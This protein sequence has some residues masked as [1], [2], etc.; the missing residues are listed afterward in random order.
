MTCK[1]YSTLLFVVILAL[2]LTLALVA[3]TEEEDKEIFGVTFEDL[4]VDYDGNPHSITVTGK[5]PAGVSVVYGSNTATEPGVYSAIAT[6]YGNG[7]VTVTLTAKLTIVAPDVDITGVTFEDL[8]VFYDGNPHEITVTG[9]LPNGVTVTYENN[10]ATEVGEYLATAVLSGKGYNDLALSATLKIMLADADTTG[11][12]FEDMTVDF[13][14]DPHELTVSGVLPEGVSVSY[15]NNVAT[16]AGEYTVSATFSQTN[17]K[18]VILTAKL[19]INEVPHA[20]VNNSEELL[21]ALNDGGLILFGADIVLD[22]GDVAAITKDTR[23]NGRGHTLSAVNYANNNYRVIDIFGADVKNVSISNLNITADKQV[24]YLRG[25]NLYETKNLTLDV[26]NVTV[27]LCDYYGFNI[28]RLN[29]N[30]NVNMRDCEIS[31]WVA[32]YNH[33]SGVTFNA[34]RCLFKG[35][36]R[37]VSSGSTYNYCT[38]FIVSEYVMVNPDDEFSI[39]TISANNVFRLTDCEIIARIL[40]NEETGETIDTYQNVID[41]R[42][43]YNNRLELF[44]ITLAPVYYE[45]LIKCAY[46]SVYIP[47]ENRDDPDYVVD[48]NKVYIDG[49]DVTENDSLVDKYFDEG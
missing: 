24:S 20:I 38:T 23:L 14:G 26:S 28:A 41:L 11:V 10:T 27:N 44:N 29:D 4:T 40:V 15:N 17:R 42:S 9:V 25:I 3:C 48:T 32:V 49:V 46:D 43:P 13:D 6:L 21:A 22:N 45:R 35:L 39:D 8:T 18:D 34:E 2:V 5:L 7:Y 37:H 47:D 16:D 1:K 30:L 33:S 36:N 12:T 19:I 31:A